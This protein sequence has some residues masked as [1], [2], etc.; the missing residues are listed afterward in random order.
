[1]S[2]IAY[3]DCFS[4][5]SGDMIIG[6]L[7]DAGA[8]FHTLQSEL[9]KLDLSDYELKT[10]RVSKQH[11]AATKF[12]VVDKGRRGYRHLKDLVAIV[13]KS[14]L[15][16]DIQERAKSIF[17]RIAT[18]EAKI[19]GQPLEKV[20][21]HEIGAVDT[22]VDVVGALVCLKLLEIEQVFCSK[23]NV[24]SGFVEFSHGKFPVPAPATA[25]ILKGV[26]TY[27]TDVQAELVTPTGAAIIAEVAAG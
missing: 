2:K 11:L 12:D 22:I 10:R 1:M 7:L 14:G 13:E 27:S 5:I 26:P 9:A 15:A 20:H 3:F 23:L 21:F 24:G 8:D 18:A 25:E 6:A 19:H 17:L 4:G 16:P